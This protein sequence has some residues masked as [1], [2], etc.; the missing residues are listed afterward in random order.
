MVTC[1]RLSLKGEQHLETVV[2]DAEINSYEID[3]RHKKL[4]MKLLRKKIVV[5][6]ECF[7]IVE[8]EV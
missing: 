3:K 7:S 1:N 2:V 4:Y 6:E 8:R 5:K